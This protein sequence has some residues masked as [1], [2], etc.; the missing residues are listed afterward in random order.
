MAAIAAIFVSG[1]G[2]TV[3][4]HQECDGSCGRS[5]CRVESDETAGC[6][7]GCE[8]CAIESHSSP[9]RDQQPER[10]HD[11]HHCTVCQVLAQ[12]PSVPAI[13]E[14]PALEVLL[15][16]APAASVESLPD[17]ETVPVVSR[18]PPA[19]AVKTAA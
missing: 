14:P 8:S 19:I 17:S 2:K 4:V 18:G 5:D 7:F 15:R 12:A 13:V 3:H 16:I 9:A 6:P 1:V 10:P 11:E